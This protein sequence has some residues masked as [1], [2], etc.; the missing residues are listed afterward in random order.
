MLALKLGLSLVSTPILGGWSPDDETSLEAWY[1]NKVGITLNGSD[2]SEWADSSTNSHD[3]AQVDVGKQPAYNAATGALTFVSADRDY[4]ITSGQIS[5]TGEFTIGFRWN[6]DLTAAG[7]ILGDNTDAG[8]QYKISL[9]DRLTIKIGGVQKNFDLDVGTFGDNY[10]LITRD[11]A[12][13]IRVWNNGIAQSDTETLAGTSLIDA[14]SV[15]KPDVDNFDGTISEIQIYSST[16]AALTANV[17]DRLS[18]L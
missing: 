18:T 11:G 17:S 16:N 12:D 15:R 3:M 2:V 5:L 9:A 13:L 8:E 1:Q 4:L 10:I 6:P 7:T 14:I